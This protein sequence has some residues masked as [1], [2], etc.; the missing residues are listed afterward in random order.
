MKPGQERP[1][2]FAERE[3]ARDE[4]VLRL[5][6]FLPYR[7]S[8]LASRTSRTLARR[9]RERFGLSIAEWRVM[10]VLGWREG[11]S[12]SEIAERTAM[13]KVK[14]SRAITRLEQRK[15]LA[16]SRDPSDRRISRHRL[17][18][19]GRAVYGQVVPLAR[20]FEEHLLAVLTTEERRL[21]FALLDRL[22]AR[23]ENLAP[24]G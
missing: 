8:V 1:A 5:D 11:L 21:L 7:L 6:R 4:P 13:D 2:P 23:I 24:D 18:A 19:A 17:T 12:A 22:D 20:A 15:L 3:W 16:R 10:A 9:Y 14:V